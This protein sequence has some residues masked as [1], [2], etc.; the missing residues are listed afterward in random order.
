M[1]Q[2]MELRWFFEQPPFAVADFFPQNL[3]PR[4]RV[5]YHYPGISD[6]TVIRLRSM[7]SI[8]TC[9]R[10][11]VAGILQWDGASGQPESW[12]RWKSPLDSLQP[13]HNELL[14]RNGWVK[15]TRHQHVRVFG[16]HDN[17]LTE[18]SLAVDRLDSGCLF[19]MNLLQAGNK[20]YWN[21]AFRAFG[22][23][24]QLM[25]NLRKT[26]DRLFQE[27]PKQGFSIDNSFGYAHWL[28]RF[29]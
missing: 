14:E 9:L 24:D 6:G 25:Y 12:S 15:I 17:R 19:L 20:D 4:Y 7:D 3:T 29:R 23:P 11:N 8:E 10:N 18:H 13:P 26:A 28:Q 2:T 27:L 21:I 22:T 5:E 1:I 16:I